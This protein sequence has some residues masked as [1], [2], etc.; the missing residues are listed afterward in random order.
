[1]ILLITVAFFTSALLPGAS[2]AANSPRIAALT[3][4]S[5]QVLDR[6]QIRPVLI[7]ETSDAVDIDSYA[8]ASIR[9]IR[10]DADGSA[11]PQFDLAELASA[12]PEIVFINAAW[13]ASERMTLRRL[14]FKVIAADPRSPEARPLASAIK[15][16]AEASGRAGAGA[17][18]VRSSTAMVKSLKLLKKTA[19]RPQLRVAV[20]SFRGG[21]LRLADSRSWSAA[22]IRSAGASPLGSSPGPES[23]SLEAIS[24]MNPDLLIISVPS[25]DALGAGK[26]LISATGEL[27]RSRT[28]LLVDDGLFSAKLNIDPLIRKVNRYLLS[29]AS[30]LESTYTETKIFESRLTGSDRKT[31]RQLRGQLT[32]SASGPGIKPSQ[33]RP[34]NVYGKLIGFSKNKD[35]IGACSATVIPTPKQLRARRGPVMLV[36]AAHCLFPTYDHL[37]FI[38]A[39]KNKWPLSEFPFFAVASASISNY[40]NQED[41][42]NQLEND[43]SQLRDPEG[44]ANSGFD[45][46]FLRLNR[47]ASR[48]LFNL[49]GSAGIAFNQRPRS[50]YGLFGYPASA[51]EGVPGGVGELYS[52]WDLNYCFSAGNPLVTDR[53]EWPA[54]DFPLLQT[55]CDVG[56]GWS[57][58]AAVS[59]E[60]IVSAILSQFTLLENGLSTR[61]GQLARLGTVARSLWQGRGISERVIRYTPGRL[62]LG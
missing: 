5:A 10:I 47:P 33:S 13:P 3:P 25:E 41:L 14:G 39:A 9:R 53:A 28:I 45:V 4:F 7:G 30:A 38:P 24:F 60:Q 21:T 2:S 15:K 54:L 26:V 16:I 32:L 27:L 56:Y 19:A 6:L 46:A 42:F 48:R 17:G 23:I 34:T 57:G 36:T 35:L 58:G 22:L 59:G 55:N 18:L 1:M 62:D 43:R 8:P 49:V 37:S 52:G 12:R 29:S 11:N 31:F 40:Y 61:Q 20:A 51:L 44:S 50:G